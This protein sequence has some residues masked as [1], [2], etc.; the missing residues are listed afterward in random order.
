MSKKRNKYPRHSSKTH[1]RGRKK[2]VVEGSLKIVKPGEAVLECEM[3]SFEVAHGAIHE[4]MD[5]DV[6]RATIVNHGPNKM[7]AHIQSV[8][9]RATHSFVG[10]FHQ[11]D[12]LSVVSPLD[13]KIHHDFFILPEDKTPE[14]YQVKDTDIVIAEILEFPQRNSAGVATLVKKVADAETADI[15]IEGLIASLG[16]PTDFPEEVQKAAAAMD[17]GVSQELSCNPSRRDLRDEVCFTIDPTD[18]RDFD[19]AISARRLDDGSFELHVHIADVTHYVRWGTPLDLE[20][21]RRTCSVYLVDRVIPMLPEELSCDICSLRPGVDRLAMSVSMH[22]DSQGHLIS[23]EPFC[24]AINSKGRL[25]YA[26][27]DE[28]LKG[29]ICKGDLPVCDEYRDEIAKAIDVANTIAQ[30][31]IKLAKKRG[32]IEFETADA[33]AVLDETGAACGVTIRKTTQATSLI[34]QA[35]LLANESVAQILSQRE[36]PACYRV[37]DQPDGDGLAKTLPV[38]HEFNLLRDD[39]GARLCL[40]DPYAIQNVLQRALGTPSEYLV[41]ALLLRAQARAVYK[42]ENR[43]HYALG[44]DAY[45]HFTSPIR[46]YP[47]DVVHRALKAYLSDTLH[48]RQQKDCKR[49]LGKICRECSQK[50]RI[51]DMAARDSQKIKM[52]EM[53]E[54]Q[55]GATFSGIISGVT[56]YGIFVVLDDTLAEGLLHIGYLGSDWYEF[57][58]LKMCLVGKTTGKTWRLGQRVAVM[59]DSCDVDKGHINFDLAEHKHKFDK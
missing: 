40:G 43:G 37:H 11:E 42:P 46:R 23:A 59:I 51:A 16:L 24:C 55:I 1:K 5:G 30:K 21:R 2:G 3:G 13:S 35:M 36:I 6:V 17:A 53:Y 47:D 8:V 31:R 56:D 39:E 9:S 15:H 25:D 29:S 32:A 41:N 4:A 20:A 22:L 44:A 14:K 33:R 7:F 12:P 52:A 28:Y 38:L 58:E 49:N 10:V 54:K 26:T 45:C 19:D 27:V 34:E 50:E 18:A 57:D 48:S